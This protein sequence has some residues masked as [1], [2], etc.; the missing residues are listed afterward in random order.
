MSLIYKY[1]AR[2]NSHGKT[3]GT[4]LRVLYLASIRPPATRIVFAACE[5][6]FGGSFPHEYGVITI[7]FRRKMQG[8][9]STEQ[10][11]VQVNTSVFSI[12]GYKLILTPCH[13]AYRS[14]LYIDLYP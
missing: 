1:R 12:S 9:E 5:S 14:E 6:F 7:E 4:T 3:I 13:R 8:A 11:K 10:N 2:N